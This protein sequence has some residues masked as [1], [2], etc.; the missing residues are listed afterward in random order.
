MR[1]F[2]SFRLP[3]PLPRPR[4]PLLLPLPPLLATNAFPCLTTHNGWTAS[5]QMTQAC[6]DVPPPAKGL[7]PFFHS[8]SII[9]DPHSCTHFQRSIC[10]HRLELVSYC[11]RIQQLWSELLIVGL[12][13]LF[14]AVADAQVAIRCCPSKFEMLSRVVLTSHR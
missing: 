13:T 10:L 8:R 6:K 14:Q 5:S 11:H 2:S 9:L 12:A 1:G 3:R 7:F 4:R